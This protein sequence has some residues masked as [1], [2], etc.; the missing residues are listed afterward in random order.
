[1]IPC[2]QSAQVCSVSV[3]APGAV[4][5]FLPNEL[6]ETEGAPLT[7]F[8]TTTVTNTGNMATVDASVLATS[9]G[10][11]GNSLLGSSSRGS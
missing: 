5:I 10:R 8:A 6:T 3:L 7:T 11:N 2:D 9:N 1:T 4:L